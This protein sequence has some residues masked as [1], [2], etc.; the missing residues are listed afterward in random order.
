MKKLAILLCVLPG[1]AALSY[2]PISHLGG[3]M[4]SVLTGGGGLPAQIVP[5]LISLAT[6]GTLRSAHWGV[7]IEPDPEGKPGDIAPGIQTCLAEH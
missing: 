2:Y 4:G 1:A 7:T 3:K 5:F 6:L